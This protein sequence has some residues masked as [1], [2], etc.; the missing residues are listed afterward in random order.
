MEQNVQHTQEAP[1]SAKPPRKISWRM[2][3]VGFVVI[4]ALGIAADIFW[5]NYVSPGAQEARR[6]QEQYAKY[7]AWQQSY[8][9]ALKADTYGGKTPKETLDLFIA[10]LEKEDVDLASKYFMLDNNLSRQK[11]VDLLSKS[12]SDGKIINIVDELKKATTSARDTGS[13]DTKEF[14]VLGSDGTPDYSIIFKINKYSQVWKIE[15]L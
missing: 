4:I 3:A 12:K 10:A 8:Q 15:S 5:Q 9:D 13:L 6:M 2:F 14:S 7:E 11:W 1:T